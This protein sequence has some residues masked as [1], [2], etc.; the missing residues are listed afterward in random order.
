MISPFACAQIAHSLSEA[1]LPIPSNSSKSVETPLVP[2]STLT[3]AVPTGLTNVEDIARHVAANEDIRHSA[4][5][6]YES[7]R[8]YHLDYNGIGGPHTAE[9]LVHA[10][11]DAPGIKHLTVIRQTGSKGFGDKV[12]RKIVESEEEASQRDN[13]KAMAFT[14]ENFDM[15]L[16]GHDVINGVPAYVLDVKPRNDNRFA[17]NGRVWISMKD[18][19]IM[20]VDGKP[21][22]NPTWMISSMGFDTHFSRDGIFWLP[23]HNQTITHVLMGGEVKISIDYGTYHNIVSSPAN[24]DLASLDE[25]K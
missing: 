15:Q 9:L 16:V 21:A 25:N 13:R 20:R 6:H 19:A 24:N 17:Y 14:T 2:S 23:K 18:F 22:K 4:L 12:L 11:Y 5:R 8:L 10:Q 3:R 1:T 7:D